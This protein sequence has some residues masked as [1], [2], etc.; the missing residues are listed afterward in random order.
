MSHRHSSG[1]D[2]PDLWTLSRCAAYLGVAPREL[3]RL[4]REGVVRYVRR[5][6]RVR[7]HRAEVDRYRK[8]LMTQP[9]DASGTGVSAGDGPLR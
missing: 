9:N 5:G 6:C 4:L 1:P 7:V 8:A 3:L 2:D